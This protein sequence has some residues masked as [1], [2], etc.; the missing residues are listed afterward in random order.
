MGLVVGNGPASVRPEEP[1]LDEWE[2]AWD[3]R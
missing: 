3:T 1:L 2:A